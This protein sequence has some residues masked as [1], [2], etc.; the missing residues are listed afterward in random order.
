MLTH[1]AGRCRLV[2]GIAGYKVVCLPKGCTHD[3][4]SCPAVDELVAFH[5]IFTYP[6][7]AAP[8][9]V[10]WCPSSWC[11]DSAATAASAGCTRHVAARLRQLTD[12]WGGTC[13]A[14]G[15]D[16]KQVKLMLRIMS[17]TSP[18][19]TDRC[20]VLM[21]AF[22]QVTRPFHLRLSPRQRG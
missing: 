21:R 20:C 14:W 19:E 5:V 2:M 3:W 6:D 1:T 17:N 4:S 9:S 13:M 18:K 22:W 12:V 7:A 11:T 15:L 16:M 8:L 10:G